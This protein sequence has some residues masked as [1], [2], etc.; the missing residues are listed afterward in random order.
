MQFKQLHWSNINL[1]GRRKYYSHYF[2]NVCHFHKVFFGTHRWPWGRSKLN[3]AAW[4]AKWCSFHFT[5]AFYITCQIRHASDICN[6]M[7]QAAS[8]Q[9]EAPRCLSDFRESLWTMH[10]KPLLILGLEAW[11]RFF[12]NANI[13]S[14][15]LWSFTMLFKRK[16]SGKLIP[17]GPGESI[18]SFTKF[19]FVLMVSSQAVPSMGPVGVKPAES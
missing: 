10:F 16:N 1:R 11:G 3:S 8:L 9:F 5:C 2:P 4:L 15:C 17:R 6:Y 19:P 13:I 12:Y 7:L 18:S 14:N